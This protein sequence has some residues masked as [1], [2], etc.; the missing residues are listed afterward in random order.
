[1]SKR[2]VIECFIYFIF[3][4]FGI[5]LLFYL[6]NG[7]GYYVQKKYHAESLKTSQ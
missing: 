5:L 7:T 1:M 4:V 2:L 3:A 6:I